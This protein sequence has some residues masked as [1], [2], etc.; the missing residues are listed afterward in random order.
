VLDHLLGVGALL[1]GLFLEKL[2]EAAQ[3]AHLAP[4]RKRLIGV[5]GGELVVELPLELGGDD[6]GDRGCWHRLVGLKGEYRRFAR[7]Y[8]P[9]GSSQTAQLRSHS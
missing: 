8:L 9:P 2:G 7:S 1:A 4:E 5:G 3:V 6:G